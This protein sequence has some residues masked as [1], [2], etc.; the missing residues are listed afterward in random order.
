MVHFIGDLHESAWFTIV[1]NHAVDVFFS[2]VLID[3]SL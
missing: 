2:K 3:H 1:E